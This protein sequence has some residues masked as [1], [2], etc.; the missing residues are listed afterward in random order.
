MSIAFG[1]EDRKLMTTRRNREL[2]EKEKTIQRKIPFGEE[3]TIWRGR[4]N[5]EGK[6]QFG[7]NSG[8]N[9]FIGGRETFIGRRNTFIG[10]RNT[11]IGGRNT[12]AGETLAGETFIGRRNIHWREKRGCRNSEAQIGNVSCATQTDRNRPEAHNVERARTS[13]VQKKKAGTGSE[14]QGPVGN[15]VE[16]R[17]TVLNCVIEFTY[18]QVS[19]KSDISFS[20]VRC[21]YWRGVYRNVR[22]V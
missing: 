1:V 21:P 17:E 22:L 8:R 2:N 4:D 13:I 7:G 6:K 3:E 12:L 14:K 11:F 10:G 9:A 20:V 19:N 15:P 16:L 5:S 18:F